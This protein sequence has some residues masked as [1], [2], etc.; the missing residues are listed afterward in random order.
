CGSGA[1]LTGCFSANRAGI[2]IRQPECGMFIW[3]T[4]SD[5]GEQQT[6]ALSPRGFLDVIDGRTR[7][8]TVTENSPC[9]IGGPLR[10]CH[11]DSVEFR[12]TP[13]LRGLTSLCVA[14]VIERDVLLAL[15]SAFEIPAGFSVSEQDDRLHLNSVTYLQSVLGLLRLR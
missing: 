8:L 15:E 6:F 4:F 5:L 9:G 12:V 7:D 1:R 3:P 13:P 11:D 14:C 2:D 10:W